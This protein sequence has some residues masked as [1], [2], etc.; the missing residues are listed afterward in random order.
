MRTPAERGTLVSFHAHPDDEVITTGG[1]IA[2]AVE[3]GHR[4]VLVFATRGEL[5]EVPDDLAP[6]ES[7]AERRTAE[8]ARAAVILGVSRVEYL[9]YRDSGMADEPTNDDDGAFWRAD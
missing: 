5:G 7:L 3:E 8:T 9:G 1:T 2:R 6:G 4:V